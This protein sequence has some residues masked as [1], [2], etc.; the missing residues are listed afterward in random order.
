MLIA[1]PPR[2]QYLVVDNEQP[3]LVAVCEKRGIS[4]RSTDKRLGKA[5]LLVRPYVRE[6]GAFDF[7]SETAGRGSCLFPL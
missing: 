4:T 2:L 1:L 6:K 7:T 3:E 5:G